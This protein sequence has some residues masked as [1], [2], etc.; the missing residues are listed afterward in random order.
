M[1]RFF[2]RL[3]SYLGE[4]IRYILTEFERLEMQLTEME[5]EYSIEKRHLILLIAT[6]TEQSLKLFR[7]NIVNVD[8]DIPEHI[9]QYFRIKNEKEPLYVKK[10]S[11]DSIF[12][13]FGLNVESITA[14]KI[15]QKKRISFFEGQQDLDDFETI[16]NK[17]RNM[18][19]H[20][21]QP[22]F[23]LDFIKIKKF[24]DYCLLFLEHYYQQL[25]SIISNSNENSIFFSIERYMEYFVNE[26][27]EGVEMFYL[28]NKPSININSKVKEQFSKD[29]WEIVFKQ[30]LMMHDSKKANN[31]FLKSDIP[32][33]QFTTLSQDLM[34]PKREWG[35]LGGQDAM[36]S[37][38]SQL[39]GMAEDN[40]KFIKFPIKIKDKEIFFGRTR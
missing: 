17:N 32:V 26:F 5:E 28:K 8:E 6:F 1:R 20:E 39:A 37:K 14:K 11:G 15:N 29:E 19:A 36:L 24:Y 22:N 13:S 21:T 34:R 33:S 18:A 23:T 27:T 31:N 16:I 25:E 4:D 2:V 9:K 12:K 7:D 35:M 30:F 3:P 38:C 40:R 10:D